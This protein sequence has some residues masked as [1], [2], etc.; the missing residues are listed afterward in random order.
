[1]ALL[2]R[3]GFESVVMQ[4]NVAC[5]GSSVR[6]GRRKRRVVLVDLRLVREE[7]GIKRRKMESNWHV[8]IS[9]GRSVAKTITSWLD[10]AMNIQRFE[11]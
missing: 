10:L 7:H 3:I 5:W 2:L 6:T 9:A 1:M 8:R 11:S 4:A